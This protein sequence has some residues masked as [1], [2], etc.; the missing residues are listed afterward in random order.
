MDT[1]KHAEDIEDYE[2]IL[3][4]YGSDVKYPE[5][6]RIADLIKRNYPNMQITEIDGGQAVYSVI[7]CLS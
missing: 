3:L 5:K 4:I 1:L 7:G 6:K 2:N